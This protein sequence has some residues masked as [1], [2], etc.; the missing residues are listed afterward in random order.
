MSTDKLPLPLDAEANPLGVCTEN[1]AAEAA[2][3][4]SREA[5]TLPPPPGLSAG[6][7]VFHSVVFGPPA[8][9]PTA[10]HCTF[11]TVTRTADGGSVVSVLESITLRKAP[12]A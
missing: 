12:G 7:D 1:C 10:H 8:G 6:Y 9:T 4:A 2:V 3:V 11:S 5:E